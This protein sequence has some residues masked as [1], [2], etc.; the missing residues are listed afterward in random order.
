MISPKQ[1]QENAVCQ[2]ASKSGSLTPTPGGRCI[3]LRGFKWTYFPL[4]GVCRRQFYGYGIVHWVFQ[5]FLSGPVNTLCKFVEIV[6]LLQTNIWMKLKFPKCQHKFKM[7][8]CSRLSRQ[9]IYPCCTWRHEPW[10][11]KFQQLALG[12]AA[13]GKPAEGQ[14]SGI[15]AGHQL[16]SKK[17]YCCLKGKW[18]EKSLIQFLPLHVVWLKS[19]H[20]LLFCKGSGNSSN[21]S[22]FVAG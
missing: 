11:E 16:P 13:D 22:S 7:W 2:W 20:L 4:C 9:Q 1:C 6:E 17:V 14:G 19:P 10:P 3:F 15:G 8:R 18:A 21:S 5:V 12:M